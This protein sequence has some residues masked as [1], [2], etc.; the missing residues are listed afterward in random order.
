MAHTLELEE[1]QASLSEKSWAVGYLTAGW[2]TLDGFYKQT[3]LDMSYTL[4]VTS[5]RKEISVRTPKF[6][7][8]SKKKWTIMQI[9]Q[10]PDYSTVFVNILSA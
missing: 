4:D 8:K 7:E 1:E 3:A 6:I 9:R 5:R 2:Q 10:S